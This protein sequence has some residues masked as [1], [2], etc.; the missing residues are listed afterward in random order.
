MS[1]FA[2]AAVAAVAVAVV[3]VALPGRDLYHAGWFNVV[4]LALAIATAVL[5]KPKFLHA[6]SN[7]GRGAVAAVALGAAF[8]ALAAAASGLLAP[9]NRTVVGAPGQRIALEDA[10]GTLIFPQAGGAA[11]QSPLAGDVLFVRPP[12]ASV[13]IGDRGRYAGFFMLRPVARTVVF[14]D[15]RDEHGAHLTVTQPSGAAFLSPVLLMREHQSIAGFDVPFDSFAV[16]A[17]HRLVRAVLFTPQQAAMMHGLESGSGPAVLFAVDDEN[18]RPLPHGVDAARAG[19]TV[20]IAGLQLRATAFD[21]PAVEVVAVPPIPAVIA[22]F[23]FVAGGLIVRAAD[24]S[25]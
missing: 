7:A 25:A 17:A 2:V 11:T 9:D 5:A 6:R 4:V 3:E 14:V 21:Y 12:R 8:A 16:P 13:T 10:G 23:V 22:G 20:A 19:A 24:R 1:A 15:A 18:D